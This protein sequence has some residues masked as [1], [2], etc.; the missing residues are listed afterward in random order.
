MPNDVMQRDP[1]ESESEMLPQ[2]PPP[3]FVRST[4]WLLILM[5][6]V[7]LLASILVKLPETVSCPFVLVSA[8]GADPIQSPRLAVVNKVC[9]TEGQTVEKGAPLFLL[10]SD[11]IR[12]WGTEQRTLNEDLHTH[13]EGL[14]KADAAYASQ[15]EIKTAEIAQAQSEVSFREKHAATS[16][17]LVARMQ[18]LTKS[19]GISQVEV[20]RYQLEA[21][22]S[23]KDFSVA[24][25]TLQQ[26]NLELAQ[27]KNE[28]AR[29]H[30]ESV[31]ETEKLK[32]RLNALQG[33][34]ENSK[35]N[36]LAIRAPYA[37]VVI[38]L[39][40]R[41]AGSVV[42]NGQELCQL[43][44]TDTKLRARLTLPESGLPKLASG[45]TVRLFFDAFPYQRYGVVNAKLDWISPAV[46]TST[47]GPHFVALT[48]L[49]AANK[50]GRRRP[51]ALRVGMTGEAR[52]V[53]GQRTIME[54]AF[55][56]IRQLR[57]NV[58]D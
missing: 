26:V 13:E 20:L 10:R 36:L 5:F 40:Q 42:Q 56:P 38:S 41:N 18:T 35:L 16:R 22:E 54:Y 46:V 6:A 17:D 48:S 58:R 45:Q 14:A 4:A 24:Q 15:L 43:S 27:L 1:M 9:V 50:T 47:D 55:E 23:E 25:R 12:G 21:A 32:M 2:D 11:E 34:L 49:E 30:D 8:A 57:E 28:H 7:A 44:A 33:D 19:G 3:W 39:A 53:V 52:I 37:G 29:V 31:S 51:L